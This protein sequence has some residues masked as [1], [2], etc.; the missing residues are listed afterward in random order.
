MYFLSISYLGEGFTIYVITFF[1]LTETRLYEGRLVNKPWPSK[2]M[3]LF[4]T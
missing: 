1:R 2:S 3:Q 4:T